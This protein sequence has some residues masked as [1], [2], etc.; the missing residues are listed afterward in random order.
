[1]MTMIM[2]NSMPFF[3]GERVFVIRERAC[4]HLNLGR[5]PPDKATWR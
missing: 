3:W 5:L 4:S 2:M 1:M